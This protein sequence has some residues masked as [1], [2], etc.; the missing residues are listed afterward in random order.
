M[1]QT[2]NLYVL[3][4]VASAQQAMRETVAGN[5]YIVDDDPA[6]RDSLETLLDAA[7]LTARTFASGIE[8]V[9]RSDRLT[10]GCLLLDVHL[11]DCD[12][13]DVLV[14]LR[15]AGVMLPVVFM[16][17][18]DYRAALTRASALGAQDVLQKPLNDARLLKA[19]H[20]AMRSTQS[21]SP[22]GGRTLRIC[23]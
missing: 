8:V 13:F 11:P 10:S 12:G 9:R 7:G 5:V 2:I 20:R 19:V 4:Q 17:G 16:T 22:Y 23:P 21:T 1:R 15:Q 14:A 6:V 18:G 3:V